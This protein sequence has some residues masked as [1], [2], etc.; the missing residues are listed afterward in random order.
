MLSDARKCAGKVRTLR[1]PWH[2]YILVPTWCSIK[3]GKFWGIGDASMRR[4]ADKRRRMRSK[5][6][7]TKLGVRL[8]LGCSNPGNRWSG[9]GLALLTAYHP[10]LPNTQS[11]YASRAVLLLRRQSVSVNTLDWAGWVKFGAWA[12][13]GWAI[14]GG[15]LDVAWCHGLKAHQTLLWSGNKFKLDTMACS[16][17]SWNHSTSWWTPS[18]WT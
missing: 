8:G 13:Q 2:S 17:D 5:C 7:Q 15:S 11:Q 6:L 18:R 1:G 4:C 9:W 10:L 3:H 14:K 12:D 16:Q